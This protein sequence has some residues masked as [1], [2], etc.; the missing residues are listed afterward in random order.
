MK[1]DKFVAILI[2]L[3]GVTTTFMFFWQLGMKIYS[4]PV[5]LVL[6][7]AL[8]RLQSPIWSAKIK[9][10][11][12]SIMGVV[13]LTIDVMFNAAGLYDFVLAFNETNL[14]TMLAS[15]GVPTVNGVGFLAISLFVGAF[16]AGSPEIL[17]N[18]S[19]SGSSGS[20]SSRKS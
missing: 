14:G 16:Q 9:S 1:V 17:W 10:P 20:S 8:T 5:S 11:V 18:L 15:Q 12:I 3:S 4:I 7:A 13:S 6:Q 19:S 2:W